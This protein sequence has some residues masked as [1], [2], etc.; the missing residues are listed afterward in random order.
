MDSTDSGSVVTPIGATSTLR[1][2]ARSRNNFDI[3][4]DHFAQIV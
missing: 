4:N 3:Q 2:Y 1:L